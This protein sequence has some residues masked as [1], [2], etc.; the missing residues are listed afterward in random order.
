[1]V[2]RRSL[3]IVFA[4]GLLSGCGED[5]ERSGVLEPG[6]VLN[7]P[8]RGQAIVKVASEAEGDRV[9]DEAQ[10]GDYD[11]LEGIELL[12]IK[13]PDADQGRNADG[14]QCQLSGD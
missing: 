3:A 14:T 13:P 10:L 4:A 2:L 5:A 9:C 11:E 12:I 8:D 6:F 1:M 7:A